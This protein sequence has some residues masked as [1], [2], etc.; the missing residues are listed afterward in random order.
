MRA[1]R[2][3]TVAVKSSEDSVREY[4]AGRDFP[5]EEEQRKISRLRVVIQLQRGHVS[6]ERRVVLKNGGRVCEGR[7][8]SGAVRG[9]KFI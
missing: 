1:R 9:P 2:W 4:W 8:R 7:R 6:G 3:S 5:K